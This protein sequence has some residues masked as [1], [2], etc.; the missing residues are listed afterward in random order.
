MTRASRQMRD[1]RNACS[2]LPVGRGS[3]GP[4]GPTLQV[5]AYPAKSTHF[6]VQVSCKAGHRPTCNSRRP[7]R[8]D[9]GS[10]NALMLTPRRVLMLWPKVAGVAGR[11]AP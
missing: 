2:H 4:L 5:S 9:I 11:Y 1:N 8:V 6:G 3:D 10:G 7:L